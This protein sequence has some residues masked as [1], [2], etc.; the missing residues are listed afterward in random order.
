MFSLTTLCRRYRDAQIRNEFHELSLEEDREGRFE[1][2]EDPTSE[3]ATEDHA[4][5]ESDEVVAAGE[6]R[7]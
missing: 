4:T 7:Q 2:L 5:L 1:S 6:I 3:V